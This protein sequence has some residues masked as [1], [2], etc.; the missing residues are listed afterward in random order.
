MKL[1]KGLVEGM[2]SCFVNLVT[3]T[4]PVMS[5]VSAWARPQGQHTTVCQ[6]WSLQMRV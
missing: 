2:T 3:L 6:Q 5:G 4:P 1:V